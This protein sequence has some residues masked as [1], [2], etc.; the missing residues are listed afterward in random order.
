MRRARMVSTLFPLSLLAL[1]SLPA[2][3]YGQEVTLKAGLSSSSLSFERRD[4][5][6]GAERRPG[7][8]AGAS[9]FLTA[10]ERGGFQVEVLYI[11][12][13]ARNVLRQGDEMQLTYLEIPVLL[14][15]D[16]WQ[17]DDRGAF[18]TVGPSAGFRL[19]G[20]Y[21][22]EGVSEE[23]GDD[24]ERVDAGLHFGAGVELGPL[25]LEA[26]YILGLRTAFVADDRDFKNRV[27]ALTAGLRWR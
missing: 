12:K 24:I 9:V 13:G 5:R 8:V 17:Q 25:V 22:D 27:I 6:P 15:A 7:L 14:H 10:A 2:G 20:T 3:A 16:F 18:F 4:E 1:L 11:Q 23:I 26:R 21:V 19:G